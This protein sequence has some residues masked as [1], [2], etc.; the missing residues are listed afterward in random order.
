[1]NPLALIPRLLLAVFVLSHLGGCAGSKLAKVKEV[2]VTNMAKPDRVLVVPFA[3]DAKNVDTGSST[4]LSLLSDS[5]EKTKIDELVKEVNGALQEELVTKLKEAGYTAV[6][7]I[8]GT[9]PGKGELLI[10][11]RWVKIDEGSA[12]K[13]N[14]IGFGAGQSLAD[15]EVKVSGNADQGAVD[16]ISFTAHADSGSKPGA[17]VLG[18]A[19]AAAGAGTAATVGANVARGAASAYQSSSAHQAKEIA[20]KIVEELQGYSLKQGWVKK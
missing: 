2:G 5:N 15:A 19:G 1:M 12:M 11:G 6:P 13:R 8:S 9:Q 14:V 7:S 20:D 10:S 16:L 18:P 4:P 17:A 3:A